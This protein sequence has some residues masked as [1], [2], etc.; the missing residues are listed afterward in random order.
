[1]RLW[2]NASD[3]VWLQEFRD[4]ERELTLN[5]P[6]GT[7]VGGQLIPRGDEDKFWI[8]AAHLRHHVELL[9]VLKGV[10]PCVLFVKYA[11]END[12]LFSTVVIDCLVPI[13]DRFDL[14]SYGFGISIQSRNWVFYDARSPQ[15]PLIKK[16]FLTHPSVKRMDRVAYPEKYYPMMSDHETAQA[17][18]YPVPFNDH[19]S[20]HLITIRDLT[21]LGALAAAGWPED[22]QCCVPGMQFNCPT[23]DA[24][25]WKKVLDFHRQCEEAAKS[26][27]TGLFLFTGEHRE[28]TAWLEENP[29]V[30]DGLSYLRAAPR[31]ARR[32][33]TVEQVIEDINN[34]SLENLQRLFVTLGFRLPEQIEDVE[35]LDDVD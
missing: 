32:E 17:L 12:P 26:V 24:S 10:K 4:K 22:Q 19:Q 33:P 34:M 6:Q 23:G 1:M 9:L 29:D 5:A 27:G 21:E 31:R 8:G 15:L 18:G 14:W 13:M 35:S 20:G 30:L 7:R 16:A 11:D 3:K 2:R 28:M 25:V